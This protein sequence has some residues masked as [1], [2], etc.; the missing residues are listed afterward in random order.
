MKK[1]SLLAIVFLLAVWSNLTH[2]ENRRPVGIDFFK[3]VRMISNLK[4]KDG[5]IYFIIRQASMEDNNYKSDLYCLEDG[6]P[7]RLTSTH[8][9]SSYFLM[10][11]GSIVFRNV[12]EAK[13]REKIRRGEPLTVYVRLTRQMG[14]AEEFLRLPY[15]VGDIKF[16]DDRH[17]F[18]TAAYD[19]PFARLL[20]QAG[21]DMDRA[22]KEKES[23]SSY[24]VFEEIP[25][26]SNGRG[27]VSGKR[28]HLYYYDDGEVKELSGT[29][30]TVGSME[31]DKDRQTLLYTSVTFQGK[32]AR[33]NRL[34]KLAV[35]TLE[36]EDISPFGQ[37]ASYGGITWLPDGEIILTVNRQLM[38]ISAAAFY[39]LHLKSGKPELLY[40]GDPYGMGVSIGSDIKTGNTSPGIRTDR[41]GFY[42]LTT[43]ADH[44]PLIHVD[45]SDGAVTF[46]NKG[47]EVILEYLP[48]RDGFLTIAMLGNKAAEIYFLDRKGL[49]T[50][51]TTVN[52]R[53]QEEYDII[54]PRPVTFVNENG[55]EITGYAIPPAGYVK[56]RKYPAILN[57]HGG[58]RTAYG[59]C[60]FH[61]MQYWANRGY[62]VIFTNPTGSDGG[63]N[64]FADISAQYGTVDYRD[65][66]LFT[67]VALRTFDFIDP[68]R[69]G[70]TGG[71]Y[72]GFMTNWII[73]HTDRFKAAASQRSIASWI[74]FSNT[75]DI[76]YT[77]T[78]TQI[79]GDVWTNLEGLWTQSPLKYADRVKTPTLFIHSDEDY[80][81]WQAEGIQMFYALKYFEVPARLCLFKG[82][83]HEL[84]RSGKPRNRVRRIEE[85]TSWMDK[86]LKRGEEQPITE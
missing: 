58:P 13:D 81:C 59:A 36:A 34:M 54:T 50:A 61:E 56:G 82:E 25:F 48:V 24:R 63:G 62:A 69:L 46:I 65:L 1:Q 73:G 64:T 76:G 83:N 5:A 40:G 42:Y 60:F 10:D 41:T 39:R 80:R 27:D 33:G 30:E 19:I 16:V 4:E 28:T 11:D 26:W 44:A 55:I 47:K 17:F 45:Y 3:E 75:T 43:V 86:Y 31:L 7:R 57:I 12:R 85:I 78:A 79:G 74:S 70:V 9:V 15:S 32:S 14:E 84:S 71:S 2:A 67:D 18:F 52:D 66:M 22:L 20:E 37:P 77:F 23:N 29:Y 38:E 53:L 6:Q 35:A 51:M 72:G 21:G 8:D 68:D 49:F